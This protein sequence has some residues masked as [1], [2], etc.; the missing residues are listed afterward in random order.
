M[1][2]SNYT[3]LPDPGNGIQH[4]YLSTACLHGNCRHCQATTN[5][6]GEDKIPATCKW[7]GNYCVCTCHTGELTPAQDALYQRF[8][9][10]VDQALAQ[11]DQGYAVN[12]ESEMST[13]ARMMCPPGKLTPG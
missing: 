13:L 6:E 8:E 10:L 3:G 11:F 12:V 2:D 9:A 1:S 7:C 5:L 4:V